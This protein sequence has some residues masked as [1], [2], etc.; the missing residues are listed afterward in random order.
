VCWFVYKLQAPSCLVPGQRRM[1]PPVPGPTW[2]REN[3]WCL[4]WPWEVPLCQTHLRVR[5]THSAAIIAASGGPKCSSAA[6]DCCCALLHAAWLAGKEVQH[7]IDHTL[8][9]DAQIGPY[10]IPCL[11]ACLLLRTNTY[12]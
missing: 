7:N 9:S 10:Q 3:P 11:A 5:I 4:W 6:L 2:C 8:L 12:P 1:S